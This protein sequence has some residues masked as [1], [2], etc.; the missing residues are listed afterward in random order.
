MQIQG[1]AHLHG[2]Q[3]INPPHTARTKPPTPELKSLSETDQL[4]ISREADLASRI[5]DLPEVRSDRVAHIRSQ[6]ES[7]V[8]ETEEKLSKALDRLLDEIG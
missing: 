7:G 1:P 3:A 6:I 8:Y 4:D 5:R 2:P